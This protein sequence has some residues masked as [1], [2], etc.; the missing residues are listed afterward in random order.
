MATDSGGR[1]YVVW[2]EKSGL[3]SQNQTLFSFLYGGTW[4]QPIVV[5]Q[6]QENQLNPTVQV[7][8]QGNVYVA[9]NTGGPFDWQGDPPSLFDGSQ[10][11]LAKL[12]G[13]TWFAR[14]MTNFATNRFVSFPVRSMKPSTVQMVWVEGN[15]PKPYTIKY[16]SFSF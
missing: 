4:S 14:Q 6:D 8:D 15:S 13:T 16:T 1:V 5:H 2:K 11:W 7:D 10:I 12:S 3:L 9:W